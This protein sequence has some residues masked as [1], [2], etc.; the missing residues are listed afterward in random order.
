LT[1]RVRA[2]APERG[3]PFRYPGRSAEIPAGLPAIGTLIARV[4]LVIVCPRTVG[5]TSPV[6]PT[7]RGI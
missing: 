4:H 2:A 6:L 7:P 5:M 1:A 3:R